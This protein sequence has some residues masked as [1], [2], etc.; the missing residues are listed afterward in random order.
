[1]ITA[2][3]N[4]LA[5]LFSVLPKL[6]EQIAAARQ[7]RRAEAARVAKD[8]RNAAALADALRPPAAPPQPPPPRV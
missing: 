5:A 6:L 3:L 7:A 1:V 8:T 2:I 4:L